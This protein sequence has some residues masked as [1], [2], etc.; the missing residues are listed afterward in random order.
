MNE[1]ISDIFDYGDE[2]VVVK[3]QDDRIDPARIKELTMKRIMNEDFREE[4]KRTVKK[5]RPVYRTVLIAAAVAVL[6]AGTALAVYHFTM[7]DVTIGEPY[8]ATMHTDTN[9]NGS[10]VFD[11][12]ETVDRSLNGLADSPEYQ[13]YVEWTEWND[14]WWAENPDPW[15]ALGEDDSYIETPENYAWYY[16]AVFPEQA[17]KLDEITEKYGLTLH[18]AM[19]GCTSAEELYSVLGVVSVFSEV[20]RVRGEYVYDDGSFKAYCTLNDSL[21]KDAVIFCAVNG[22]FTLIGGSLPADYEEWTYM[23]EDGTEVVLA[24]AGDYAV[25]AAD[26]EGAF[27]TVSFHGITGRA[28]LERYADGVAFAA[29]SERFAGKDTSDIAAA[30]ASMHA[31][32]AAAMEEEAANMYAPFADKAERDE[33]VFEELGHYTIKALPEGFVFRYDSAEWKSDRLDLLWPSD[34]TYTFGGSTWCGGDESDMET[35][36]FLTIDYT[37]YYDRRDM[38]TVTTAEE[39]ENGKDY[40]RANSEDL[41]ETMVGGYNAYYVKGADGSQDAFLCWYDTDNDLVFR[42]SSTGWDYENNLPMDVFSEEQLITIAES[43]AAQ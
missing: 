42:L 19:A 12:I 15:A 2:I 13:A 8:P 41:T 21:E 10:L 4:A 11:E 30:V 25:L 6:L 39:Y 22:S 35:W 17:E 18:T 31:A 23:T 28:E 14:A 20:Y 43:V 32:E 16:N 24:S 37:R 9:E 40:Y 27:I 29:L 38:E 33:A 34:S 3:E 26:T 1:R 7:K 36:S 5:A